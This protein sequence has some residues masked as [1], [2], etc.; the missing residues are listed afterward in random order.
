MFAITGLVLGMFAMEKASKTENK[1]EENIAQ[2][3]MIISGVMIVFAIIVI[4]L[5]LS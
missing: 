2:G 3:G 1:Q 5:A 4:I